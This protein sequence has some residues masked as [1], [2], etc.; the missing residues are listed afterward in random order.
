[1]KILIAG[2]SGLIGQSLTQFFQNKGDS[3]VKLSRS[4]GSGKIVWNPAEGKLDSLAV[5]GFDAIVNLAGENI[6]SGRWS[7]SKKK[8]ILESRV[9]S[10]DLLARTIA[11]LTHPPRVFVNASAIGF[12]GNR[13]E[14]LMTESDQRGTGFLAEVCEKWESA[15]KPVQEK[16]VRL[17]FLR[18]GVVLAKNGGALSR[19]LLPFRM[20]LGGRLASG[21]QSM[22]W[23]SIF[24]LVRIV[25][26]IL[27][28]PTIA[29]AVNVVAPASVTNQEFTKALGKLLKRPTLFPVPAFALKLLLGE[30]AE[31][32]LL[33]S[34]RVQPTVLQK[35]GYH[36]LF[37]SLESAL[38]KELS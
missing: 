35:A 20:G 34:Q 7:V 17:V 6:A 15:A 26:F 5:E 24:E 33:T 12:Y 38:E 16:G 18:L 13:G 14:E 9:H 21:R 11:Q 22:S 32:L 28:N 30:M 2:A 27:E 1:M 29:G 19:M 8:A 10:T 23:I 31:E 36:Y 37:P 4:S 3:V 25:G